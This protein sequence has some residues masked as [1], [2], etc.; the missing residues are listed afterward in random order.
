MAF[1]LPLAR[2]RSAATDL[3]AGAVH[4]V[5]GGSE[6]WPMGGG[7][8]ASSLADLVEYLSATAR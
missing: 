4:V 5:H 6:S 2:L 1:S 8:T 7:I 3:D